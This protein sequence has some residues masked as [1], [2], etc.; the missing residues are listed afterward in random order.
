MV[1]SRNTKGKRTDIARERAERNLN[2]KRAETKV[3]KATK[4][5][6]G[7]PIPPKGP[8]PKKPIPPTPPKKGSIAKRLKK[9]GVPA[10]LIAGLLATRDT[11]KSE[12]KK[13]SKAREKSLKEPARKKGPSGPSMTSMRAPSTGPKPRNK[14]VTKRPKGPSKQG[15]FGR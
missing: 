10:T 1:K 11:K 3:T 4:P 2:K 5:T 9:Y 15:S 7:K 12:A 14:N 8:K 6:K 13:S